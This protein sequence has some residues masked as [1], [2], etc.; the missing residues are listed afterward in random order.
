VLGFGPSLDVAL[1]DYLKASTP[2]GGSVRSLTDG[3]LHEFSQPLVI[4]QTLQPRGL[5]V[6]VIHWQIRYQ[7]IP[8]QQQPAHEIILPIM[9][10]PESLLLTDGRYADLS[11]D[12]EPLCPLDG[13]GAF[14]PVEA[15][16]PE[17]DSPFSATVGDPVMLLPAADAL[18]EVG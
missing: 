18:A 17:A 4:W 15:Y 16:G 1:A 2:P 12:T 14:G 7:N 9:Q 13:S 11:M 3:C 6:N 5:Q 10:V 8:S